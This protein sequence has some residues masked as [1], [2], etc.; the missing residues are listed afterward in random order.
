M[1]LQEFTTSL[2]LAQPPENIS[3]ILKALWYAGK[4]NWDAAHDTAQEIKTKDGSWIHA[5]LHR[6][7]GDLGNASYW[8]RLASKPVPSISLKE[9]LKEI[10]RSF[11]E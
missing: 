9:E 8:Y 10:T 4:N 3:D 5:Y 7:E 2:E 11:L 1:T 6:V